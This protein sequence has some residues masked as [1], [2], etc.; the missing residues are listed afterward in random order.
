MTMSTKMC[1]GLYPPSNLV[2]PRFTVVKMREGFNED[3]G[4]YGM[5]GSNERWWKES[6]RKKNS[7]F[8]IF[9][10]FGLHKIEEGNIIF[11]GVH[12]KNVSTK[13]WREN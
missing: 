7:S 9:S 10:L 11:I 8:K 12:L 13:K 1:L 6:L 4:L 2:V 3:L 5:F